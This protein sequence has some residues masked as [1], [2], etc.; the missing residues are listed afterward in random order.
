MTKPVNEAARLDALRQLDILDSPPSE[1]FDRITRMASQIFGLPVSAISLTDDDRQWFKSRVGI[2]HTELSRDRAPCAEVAETTK[3]LVIPDLL[4]HPFYASSQLASSGTRFYAGA[5]LTTRDGYGLGSLCVLGSEPRTATTAE[6]GALRDLAAMAMAQIELQH[7]FGRIDPISGLPNRQ[8]FLDDLADLTRD[9]CGERRLLVMLDLARTDQIDNMTRV[10]GSEHVVEMVK[11]AAL[12]L[13]D[14]LSANRRAYHVAA[15]QFV[16]FA[17]PDVDD[18]AYVT[19]LTDKVA[20]CSVKSSLRFATTGA[21]GVAPITLGMVEP[22]DVLRFAHGAAQDARAQEAT[23]CF[24]SS[25]NDTAHRRR[26]ELLRDF[27]AAL[28]SEDQLSL[29][30][31]PRVDLLS[32]QCLGAEVLLRWTH[33]VLGDVSPA[34]FIP[35]IEQTWHAKPLTHWVVDRALEQLG[36]WI[37]EGF[38]GNLSINLSANNLEEP[39]FAARVQLL[40]LKHRIRAERIE[41]E[42]TESA[43]MRNVAQAREQLAALRDA[44]VRLAIDDFGTGYSSLAYLQQLPVDVVKIDQSFM[45]DLDATISG[46]DEQT[47]VRTMIRLSHELGYR[48]VA[49]GVETEGVAACLSTM[50]CDEAQGFLFAR[51]MPAEPFHAWCIAHPGDPATTPRAAA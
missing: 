33:P 48:V 17:E 51:P 6:M 36:R 10:L 19:L 32:R 5:P 26:Y 11:T 35:L 27:E 9:H 43:I 14:A 49:E 7:A 45:R 18:A 4:D 2:E 47:L 46:G 40:L 16:F 39:D 24:F 20:E 42:V 22:T 15:T 21:V 1:S 25:A 37:A 28:A 3:P 38:T 12:Q 13:R 8:Q 23:V 41:L 34:E 50:E 44:G 29:V 31:Q 30:Y